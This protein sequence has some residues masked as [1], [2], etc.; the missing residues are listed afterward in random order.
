MLKLSFLVGSRGGVAGKLYPWGTD[1]ISPTLANYNE[2][3]K[4]GTTPIGSYGA[5]GYELYDMAGNVWEWTWDWYGDYSSTAQTDP[6]G[7]SSGSNRVFRGG[8]WNLNAEFC[9]VAN[10][11]NGRSP[12]RRY[13][14]SGF[15]SI[16]PPDQP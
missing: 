6:R 15:R 7:P 12:G 9:R 3:N 10:R 11:P 5:N 4:N 8:S 13:G 16:L 14:L 2:S 1:E